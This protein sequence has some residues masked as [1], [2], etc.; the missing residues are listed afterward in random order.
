MVP[1]VTE[2]L[3]VSVGGAGTHGD[4]V[5]AV[6]VTV[7]YLPHD[8]SSGQ[9]FSHVV[10][11]LT[12]SDRPAIAFIPICVFADSHVRFAGLEVPSTMRG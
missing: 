1:I 6:D 9:N 12:A 8:S 10:R 7:I 5:S 2:M 11:V 4:G 3:S